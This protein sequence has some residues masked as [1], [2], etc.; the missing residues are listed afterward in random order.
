[1]GS[2]WLT[3]LLETQN[4]RAFHQFDGVCNGAHNASVAP[5]V[6]QA[7]FA[8]G[9]G[10]RGSRPLGA[11]GAS[12]A[13]EER[14]KEQEYCSGQCSGLAT[15]GGP[16]AEDRPCKA[17]AA[18]ADVLRAKDVMASY[19]TNRYCGTQRACEAPKPR[20]VVLRRDNLV[21][22]AV[23]SLKS[24]CYA[25][26]LSNH[27]TLSD[28]TNV[29]N[30]TFLMVDPHLF[31]VRLPWRLTSPPVLARA[32]PCCSIHMRQLEVL[33]SARHQQRLSRLFPR[34]A[35]AATTTY[36]DLQSNPAAALR[37]L[38]IELGLPYDDS[39][40]AA[41][42]GGISAGKASRMAGSSSSPSSRGRMLLHKSAPEQLQQLLLNYDGI[43]NTTARQWP[44]LLPQL[45]SGRARQ[46]APCQ[47]RTWPTRPLSAVPGSGRAVVVNCVKRQCQ[48][49]AKRRWMVPF[50]HCFASE[51]MG[52]ALCDR[53]LAH[54]KRVRGAD[55]RAAS[56]CVRTTDRRGNADDTWLRGAGAAT[57]LAKVF[58]P[59]R[60]A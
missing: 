29:T 40:P 39:T 32:H 44:C 25:R 12:E 15:D 8:E 48:G 6:P 36:E 10:C 7:L 13:V 21:K 47:P 11:A 5:R 1:M 59:E 2:L 9:C 23:S 22:R 49:L 34:E 50:T 42:A 46:W 27:A 60:R 41:T 30:P 57:L 53:A 24:G 33:N 43:A 14:H 16:S 26:D 37:R 52:A 54:A 28:V 55:V 45:R 31:L 4:V 20:L 17:V 35:V 58:P 56:L 18:M 38:F 3:K 19:R 51:K